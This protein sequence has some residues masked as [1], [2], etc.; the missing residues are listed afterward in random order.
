MGRLN[1]LEEMPRVATVMSIETDASQGKGNM[2]ITLPEWACRQMVNRCL[3]GGPVVLRAEISL[4]HEDFRRVV[5][6]VRGE[7]LQQQHPA[8]RR[9][10]STFGSVSAGLGTTQPLFTSNRLARDDIGSETFADG[11]NERMCF[12]R[13]VAR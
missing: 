8:R 6:R 4:S 9:R 13:L 3:V 5:R 7:A 2:G 11:V 12:C 1:S 10:S